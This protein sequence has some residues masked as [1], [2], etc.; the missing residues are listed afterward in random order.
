LS[1]K[2]THVSRET[3]SAERGILADGQFRTNR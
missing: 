1:A 2:C 3:S